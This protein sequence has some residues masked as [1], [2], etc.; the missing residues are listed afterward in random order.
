M[1]PKFGLA[2]CSVVK[3]IELNTFHM[4]GHPKW[5]DSSMWVHFFWG[6]G[7]EG[8]WFGLEKIC[9]SRH[10]RLIS[11]CDCGKGPR[12]FIKNNLRP[13]VF[14]RWFNWYLMCICVFSWLGYVDYPIVFAPSSLLLSIPCLKSKSRFQVLERYVRKPRLF[15]NRW[16]FCILRWFPMHSVPCH[17]L[18]FDLLCFRNDTWLF[19][20]LRVSLNIA[21][22]S[23]NWE[24]AQG[25]YKK[26]LPGFFTRFC[27]RWNG[28]GF[29][30]IFPC[31][32]KSR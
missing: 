23:A 18:P 5:L 30:N 29:P 20:F 16:S 25:S 22:G 19:Q 13:R 32:F 17:G 3:K 9:G 6:S 28:Q 21:S 7:A 26:M 24:G 4:N 31:V 10:C 12:K 8:G 2:S 14:L 1:L 11:S 15:P 27:P